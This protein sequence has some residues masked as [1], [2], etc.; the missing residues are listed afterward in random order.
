MAA[1]IKKLNPVVVR[2]YGEGASLGILLTKWVS[3]ESGF[4][5]SAEGDT[6]P[7]GSLTKPIA[8]RLFWYAY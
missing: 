3:H 8:P 4:F 1:T 2:N 6:A 5:I 7:G